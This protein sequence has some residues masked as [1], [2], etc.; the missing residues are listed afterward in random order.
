[1]SFTRQEIVWDKYLA[2]LILYLAFIVRYIK[3]TSLR[4]YASA[5]NMDVISCRYFTEGNIEGG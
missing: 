3:F 1:M 2:Y 4:G 5:T